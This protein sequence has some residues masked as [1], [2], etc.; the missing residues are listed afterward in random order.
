M[1]DADGDIMVAT[2][3]K[4][5]GGFEVD[6]AEAMAARHALGIAIEAGLRNIELESDCLKL[7]SHLRAGKR[8][9]TSFGNIV[10]DIMELSKRCT[11]ISYSHVGR[12]GNQVA[13][14]LAGF[15]CKFREPRVWIEEGPPEI[16][17]LVIRDLIMNEV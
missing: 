6:E 2:C 15:N 12:K 16:L 10:F 13:H 9:N 1:R 11:R 8:E 14:N 7:I 3:M 5:E 17:S 4:Q